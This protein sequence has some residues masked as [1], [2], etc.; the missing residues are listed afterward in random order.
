MAYFY[1]PLLF[2]LLLLLTAVTSGAT[3]TERAG[4]LQVPE[5][6]FR[7]KG[8]DT[9]VESLAKQS[10]ALDPKGP[11][12]NIIYIGPRGDEAPNVTLLLRHVTLLD[13]LQTVAQVA[14]LYLRVD[15]NAIML[16]TDPRPIERLESRWY[17]VTPDLPD[18]ARRFSR[19]LREQK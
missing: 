17:S 11:G 18:V 9:V 19:E 1:T 6:R 16:S 13:A 8:A 14:G 5:L 12:V 10:Q 15:A 7:Q 3:I 4:A 2:I